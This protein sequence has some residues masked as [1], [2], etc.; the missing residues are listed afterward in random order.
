M[1]PVREK[2]GAKL[3]PA[4]SLL[5]P[6][7]QMGHRIHCGVGFVLG[8]LHCPFLL[9]GLDAL[10]RLVLVRRFVRHVMLPNYGSS[11]QILQRGS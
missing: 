8:T 9:D 11:L 3:A 1:E 6:H 7:P 10:L 4:F 5:L 2:A